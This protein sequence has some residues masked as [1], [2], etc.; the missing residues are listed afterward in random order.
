[1]VALLQAMYRHMKVIAALCATLLVTG[2]LTPGYGSAARTAAPSRSDMPGEAR[3]AES[4]AAADNSVFQDF[5]APGTGTPYSIGLH[6]SVPR[7][8]AVI[9]GGST[10]NGKMMQLAYADQPISHNSIAFDRTAT[11][12]FDQVVADFDFRVTPG[13]GRADGLGFALLK[14]QPHGISGAVAP[15]NPLSIA[16]EP[17]FRESLGIGFDVY[18][19]GDIPL[20]INDT[21]VSVHF[22]SDNNLLQMFD[23]RPAVDL[24]AGQWIH[25][26]IIMRPGGGHSDVSVFLT[27]CGRPPVAVVDQY[28]VAGFT[29]YESRVRF[30][31]RSGGQ[32]A[33]QD[34]DNIQVQYLSLAQTALPVATKCASV[35]ESD[36]QI[37]LAFNRVGSTNGTLTLNYTTNPNSAL[38]GSD[39]TP[40][41]N[42]LTFADGEATKMLTVPIINDTAEESDE[43]FRVTLSAPAGSVLAVDPPVVKVTI[44]DDEAGRGA[45]HWSDVIPSQVVPIHIHLL[46]NGKVLYWD[47]HNHMKGWELGPLLWDMATETAVTAGT[48]DYDLFC[49]G[50]ALLPDGRLLVTGGHIDMPYP[51]DSG[52]GEDKASI[53]DPA[54][55]TWLRLPQMNAGRWYPSNVSLADGDMLVVGGGY[56]TSTQPITIVVNRIPQVFDTA[57]H[58]WRELTGAAQGDVPDWADYYPFLYQAPN[59][60]VFS[61][62][63]QRMA[64]YLDTSGVGSWTDVA[65][66]SLTYRDYG[67]S[68]MYDDGKVLITGGSDRDRKTAPTANTQ[69]IDLNLNNP[70]WRSVGALHT[71]RWHATT[72]LLPDGTVL[73]TGG[74]SLPEFDNYLGAALRAELWNPV[75]EKWTEMAAHSRYRGYHS[76][77][78]LLPDG[79]VLV[80]GGGHP[81]K[82]I[83]AQYNFEIY[84]PPYLFKGPRPT[85]DHAPRQI[86]YG[87]PFLIETPNPGEVADVRLIRLPS[88]THAFNQNQGIARLEIKSKSTGGVEV[89][90]PADPNRAPPGHYMLFV[91]NSDGVPSVARIIQ[92][93]DK[94]RVY[95][96]V[97]RR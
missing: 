80:G 90:A 38:E 87:Q 95:L 50:H 55:N 88:I 61:A 10:G 40:I 8:P 46:P 56:L 62:G 14:T 94:L 19:S 6:D 66:S 26:R 75:D 17:N 29:P 5:D 23:A 35:V 82:D 27:Q 15:E 41:S 9:D 51:F 45:G 76:T 83:G 11:G 92:V 48:V 64:R 74:S 63:P 59:G 58:T 16:E 31:A 97:I 54:T 86:S 18:R 72:T 34:I 43:S 47:R 44:V 7:P 84:S 96:P 12:T 78:L 39:Y 21:H 89:T 77:A 36:G 71:G 91:L 30:A 25:A 2:S 13:T 1:M 69:V 37:A 79:R 20:D 65:S 42:T 49:S 24:A 81:E 68:V 60:K 53:Y 52:V 28:K 93:V 73:A 33:A 32:A 3:F 70:T 57:T 4:P 67:T 85:I 22:N